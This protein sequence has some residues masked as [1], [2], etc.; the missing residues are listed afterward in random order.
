MERRTIEVPGAISAGDPVRGARRTINA[1]SDGLRALDART[2]I[3]GGPLD[4]GRFV[5]SP[6]H[7][8]QPWDIV[9]R[10]ENAGTIWLR[11]GKLIH[12]AGATNTDYTASGNG[13][14]TAGTGLDLY[15]GTNWIHAKLTVPTSPALTLD[16]NTTGRRSDTATARYWPL[17]IIEYASASKS[18]IATLRMGSQDIS[19]TVWQLLSGWSASTRRALDTNTSGVLVWSET[20]DCT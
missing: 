8:P 2:N 20:G 10:D 15:N 7:G 18:M 9:K 1:L 19:A 5:Q 16:V 3:H 11:P 6:Q 12:N 13:T 4:L 14:D 17:W